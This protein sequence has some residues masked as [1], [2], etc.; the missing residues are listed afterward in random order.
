MSGQILSFMC[1]YGHSNHIVAVNA[2]LCGN[3]SAAYT[4]F[5]NIPFCVQVELE[6]TVVWRNNF[7]TSKC[8]NSTIASRSEFMICKQLLILLVINHDFLKALY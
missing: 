5:G 3:I 8:G 4:T 1:Y 7:R 2:T 6:V